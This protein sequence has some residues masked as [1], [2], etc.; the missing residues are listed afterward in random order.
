MELIVHRK[1]NELTASESAQKENCFAV[2]CNST[3]LWAP[4]FPFWDLRFK[5]N[6]W[7][8]VFITGQLTGVL[9]HLKGVSLEEL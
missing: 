2:I 4:L 6:I 1:L 5:I 3:S 7:G 8:K 9:R